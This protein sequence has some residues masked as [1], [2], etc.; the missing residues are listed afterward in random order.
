MREIAA[1]NLAWAQALME[2]LVSAGLEWL[3]ISPGSRNTPLVLA[4]ALQ[5][6]LRTRVILDERC[7]AFTALGLAKGSGRPVALVAT[8]GSAPAHW[9]PA[10]IEASESGVPLILLSADRPWELH[11]VGANQTTDQSRL[12]DGHLRAAHLVGEADDHPRCLA[13]L[14]R[15]GRQVMAQSSGLDP[16]PVHLNLPF[17]EPLVPEGPLPQGRAVTVAPPM[18]PWLGLPEELPTTLRGAMARGRGLLLAG[19][20]AQVGGELLLL[21]RHLGLPLLADPLADLRFREGV[22][23]ALVADYHQRLSD[24]TAREGLRP[25]WILQFGATPLSSHLQEALRQWRTSPH[26][27]VSPRGRWHDPLNLGTE[28]LCCDPRA[29]CEALRKMLPPRPWSPWGAEPAPAPS[30]PAR[31]IQGLVEGLPPHSLLF[32]GNS[33][34]VRWFDAWSGARPKRIAVH[35]NRGVSG[36]DGNL[37]TFLGLARTWRGGGAKVALVGDLTFQHDLGALADSADLDAVVLVVNNAGG[38][39]FD[40]LPQRNLPEYER[41]WRTPQSF[42]IEGAA[43][44]FGVGYRRLE[45][46]GRIAEALGATL[47]EGGFWVLEVVLV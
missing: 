30:A 21:A 5:P 8:S 45:A 15:L 27:V 6:G 26:W 3:V 23:P 47:A 10:V 4:A 43:A 2:G 1:T 35:G 38:G 32:L 41:F 22:P 28:L 33:L 34:V 37:A 13:A 31:L 42:S 14:R 36:I 39:I 40:H 11:E 16:G 12:F 9:Y 29:L 46:P 18:G 17:R 25:Q 20:G 7:A 19:R 24:P 44:A